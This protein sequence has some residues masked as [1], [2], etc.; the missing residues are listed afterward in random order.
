M[1]PISPLKPPFKWLAPLLTW[2]EPVALELEAALEAKFVVDPALLTKTEVV[3]PPETTTEVVYPAGGVQ[4][5]EVFATVVEEPVFPVPP[6]VLG[7]VEDEERERRVEA[8][9]EV[10]VV[11]VESVEDETTPDEVAAEEPAHW[12]S[13]QLL[14]AHWLSAVQNVSRFQHRTWHLVGT[15]PTTSTTRLA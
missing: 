6:L 2:T 1:I 13:T 9:I 14:V 7:K 15:Y 4:V 3:L 8:W 5:V 11:G 12:P 10:V